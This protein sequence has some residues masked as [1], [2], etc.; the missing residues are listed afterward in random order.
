MDTGKATPDFLKME[1]LLHHAENAQKQ[2]NGFK[3]EAGNFIAAS[4]LKHF[5]SLSEMEADDIRKFGS[6]LSETMRTLAED[7]NKLQHK[8]KTR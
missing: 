3:T 8:I 7:L 4:A 6:I 5:S 2:M 1:L